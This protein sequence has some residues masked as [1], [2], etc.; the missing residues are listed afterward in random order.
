LV[1]GRSIHASSVEAQGAS[2]SLKV[3]GD[4]RIVMGLRKVETTI[5]F[6]NKNTRRIIRTLGVDSV[7]QVKPLLDR[8]DPADR[9]GVLKLLNQLRTLTGTVTQAQDR[10]R[11]LEDRQETV[12]AD[13]HIS[14]AGK[15]EA[16]VKVRIGD[17][18]IVV[19]RDSAGVVFR[20]QNGAVVQEQTHAD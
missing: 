14:V 19:P 13:A 3:S 2:T 17:A 16:D 5:E 1:A 20:R 6:C 15:I 8:M 11:K 10:R 4:P 9:A 7:S 12:L 18:T